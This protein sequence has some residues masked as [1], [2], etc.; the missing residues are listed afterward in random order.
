M[1]WITILAIYVSVDA[2]TTAAQGPPA[3]WRGEHLQHFPRDIPRPELM[4]RMREFS[5]VRRCG[6]CLRR[7]TGKG[8][9]ASDAAH[10]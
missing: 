7:E 4:Q 1:R 8:Q 5:F 3:P 2:G 10:G 6:V 9:G